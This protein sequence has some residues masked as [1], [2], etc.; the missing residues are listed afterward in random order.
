MHQDIVLVTGGSGMIGRA[1]LTALTAANYRVRA[2]SRNAQKEE[3]GVEWIQGDITDAVTVERA[4][5]GVKSIV[6]LAAAKNDEKDSDDINIGGADCIKNAAE[7]MGVDRMIVLSTQSTKLPKK[8][9]YGTTK[10]EADRILQSSAVPVTT[11]VCSIVY[12]EKT[13]GIVGS[14]VGFSRL[15]FL[16]VIGP[17]TPRFRPIHRDDLA[18]IIVEALK[19]DATKNRVYDIGGPESLSFDELAD[20]ILHAQGLIKKHIHL[21]IPIA[22]GLARACA[23]LK[24][25]PVTI[26][27]VW[28]AAVD[29]PMNL[30]PFECDFISRPR[31]F[32]KGLEEMF[33]PK[34][35]A[36][37]EAAAL[38]RYVL[39]LAWVPDDT[40][41]DRYM[42]ALEAHGIEQ[43]ATLD[44]KVYAST[45]FM[46][47]LDLRAKSDYPHGTL[48]KK[49]TVA[50]AI[51]ECMPESADVLLPKNRSIAGVCVAL[52][53]IG[54]GSIEAY[55]VS[56]MLTRS[57][58]RRN[59]L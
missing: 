36:R 10:M 25:P 7:K 45:L 28:G 43:K 14:I 11:L 51:A 29:V 18:I 15:P 12:G 59:A 42:K 57:F 46:R 9:R 55:V 8:G 5:Q 35:S 23:F 41:I 21:P 44:P 56:K 19:N 50:A 13:D 54:I 6:H 39:P 3:N 2:L 52:L 40:V 31:T 47:A 4:M 16:P 48:R 32:K 30:L 27:N 34:N 37:A 20:S 33:P 24:K 58:L 1:L 22:L 53:M 49:I 26:S 17:G 38:L